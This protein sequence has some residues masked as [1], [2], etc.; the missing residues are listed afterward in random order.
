MTSAGGVQR[1]M[2]GLVTRV[3][4]FQITKA[5]EHRAIA[6]IARG[7][8]AVKHVDTLRHAFHQIFRRAH[9]HQIARL[10]CRQSVW[11]VR[12]D[13]QHLLFGFAHTDT[14][15][16]VARKVHVD[17]VVERFL[18]QVFKH[19]TLHNAKQS[20]R[21]FQSMKLIVAAL[22]P[23]QTHLHRLSG[24]S[25]C[26]EVALRFIRR[27]FVQLHHDVRVQHRLNLH[28]YFG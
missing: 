23:A 8:D 1:L 19:A 13:L 7:H 2:I 28:A 9:T 10:V 21:I 5:C 3:A 6:R 14:A 11:R 22:G 4:Q 24:F 27:A 20:I 17:Q 12:H 26:G 15:N 25:L 18:A 16:G